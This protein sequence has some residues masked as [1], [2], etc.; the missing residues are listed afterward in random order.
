M[1]GKSAEGEYGGDGEALSWRYPESLEWFRTIHF[2][3]VYTKMHEGNWNEGK[4][5]NCIG[6]STGKENFVMIISFGSS[7]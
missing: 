3:E 2:K 6:K 1:K 7:S 4:N 5:G